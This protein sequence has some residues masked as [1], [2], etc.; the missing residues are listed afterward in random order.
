MIYSVDLSK[1]KPI[2]DEFWAYKTKFIAGVNENKKMVKH[3]L[4]ILL[5]MEKFLQ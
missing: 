1:F 4:I 2:S 3:S 5:H